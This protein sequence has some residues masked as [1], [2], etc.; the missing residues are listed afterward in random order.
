M[1][2]QKLLSLLALTFCWASSTWAEDVTISSAADLMTF[3]SRVNGGE[4][5]LNATLTTDIDLS[6]VLSETVTWTPI[7]NNANKYTGTFDGGGH[8][9]TNFN[10]TS[11][12]TDGHGLFG[13]ISNATVKNFSISGSLSFENQSKNTY[14]G[15]IGAAEGDAVTIS[16]IHSALNI[17]VTNCN[18]HTGGIL[19]STVTSGNPVCVENCEYSGIMTHEGS[20]GDCQAGILGYTYNGGVKNCIFSGTI[21]GTSSKYGGILGYCK[22][23]GFLGVKNCLSIGKIVANSDNTTAAAIIAN[24]NA[25][26]TSNVK[27]NYYMLR[28]GSTTDIAIGNKASSC[29]APVLVTDA[30]LASGEV[31]YK[32]N[33]NTNG[34]TNWYQTIGAENY[35]IPFSTSKRVYKKSASAYASFDVADEKIQISGAAD[36][37]DFAGVVNTGGYSLNAVLTADIDMDGADI[38]NFPI[39]TQTNPYTGT[40]DGQKHKISNLQLINASAPTSYGMFNTGA[41]V[42]LKNFWL[43]SSCAIQGTEEVGLIGR[44]AGG[45]GHFEGL[46]NRGDVTGSDRRDGGIIGA[47]WGN[48]KTITIKN[49]WTTGRITGGAV[50]AGGAA[51]I[52]AWF[53]S[54]TMVMENCWTIAEVSGAT[55]NAKYV[56]DNGATNTSASTFTNCYSLN[57]SQTT[58]TTITTTDPNNQLT[59]GELCYLLNGSTSGG[60]NWYQTLGTDDIPYPYNTGHSI[61]YAEHQHC[62]GSAYDETQLANV[63]NMDAH[64]KVSGFCTYCGEPDTE[65][66]GYITPNG[67]GIYEID[68]EAKL[69]WFASFVSAGTTSANVAAN[70]RL[71]DNITL[72]SAWT[73]PIGTSSKAYTGTFDGQGHSI[74][75]FQMTTTGRG[76]L[77][78]DVTNATIQNFSISG[79]LTVTGGTGSGLIAWATSSTIVNIHSALTIEVTKSGVHHVG[80][81]VGSARGGNTIDRCSFSGSMTVAAGSTDNFAGIIAYITDNDNVTNCANYGSISFSGA[82]SAAGGVVGYLNSP[83]A[84]VKNCLNTGS[85]HYNGEGSPTYG[86]AILGRTKNTNFTKVTNNYWLEGSAYGSSAKDNVTDPLATKSSTATQLASG[87]VAYLLN[88]DQSEINWYQTIGT[89][90]YP[91]LSS[92][93]E[94]VRYVGTAGYTTFYDAANDWDLLGDAH[95]YIGTIN[96]S[97]LHLDEIDDIPAGNAVVIGGTY[98]NKVSATATADTD[99][100]VLLGS[101]GSAEGDGVNIFALANGAKG[102]GFYPVGDGVTIPAGKAYLDMKGLLIKEFLAFDFGEDDPT[103][104]NDLRDFNDLKDSKDVIYNLAGQRISKMQK[105]INIINGKKILK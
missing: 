14:N 56:Y 92:A 50:N 89:N 44:H 66:A 59:N 34:G 98:Y 63:Q 27:N 96:G 72:T 16:G 5:G 74:S 38:S 13:R 22:I 93:S 17:T 70:A 32:L 24:W 11:T 35:P 79:N 28:E 55:S 103:G 65:Y 37:T 41:N 78:G 30:T 18:A 101:D 29:E 3:A 64:E 12:S 7:G 20:T 53:N 19:G 47:A 8:A 91:T 52:I 83:S 46:G 99:G 105:G 76:G 26:A 82:G 67:E 58:C 36:L 95:A 31:C 33:E 100:N 42:T 49:C 54:A 88:G 81:V 21:N 90:A 39:G 43:D 97:A 40:F 25:G 85:V 69:N 2:K 102:V 9:I 10:Y 75:A 68:S 71:T 62:D 1:M 4:T 45:G 48:N 15:T 6:E 57:G 77:F 73:T 84:S 61:V 94:Q 51:A 87:E 23:P 104:L 80:G 60:T 86:G